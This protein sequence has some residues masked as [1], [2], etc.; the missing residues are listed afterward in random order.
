MVLYIEACESGS[1]FNRHKLPKNINSKCLILI[2]NWLT[3]KNCHHF[4]VITIENINKRYFFHFFINCVL[5]SLNVLLFLYFIVFATTAA[6]AA[7]S[8]YA[9]YF[10]EEL[11]TYLGDVYSVKWMENSDHVILLIFF[12]KKLDTC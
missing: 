3:H 7:E 8:S 4:A 9:C 6:N 1:L 5:K 2:Y 12:V 10:D 11:K